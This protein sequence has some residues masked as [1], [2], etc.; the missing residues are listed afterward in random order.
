MS[1]TLGHKGSFPNSHFLDSG[2]K[3]ITKGHRALTAK[4]A[5]AL[6]EIAYITVILRYASVSNCVLNR[7][8]L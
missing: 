2:G 1:K 3:E 5:T 7:L 4:P 6:L 8:N